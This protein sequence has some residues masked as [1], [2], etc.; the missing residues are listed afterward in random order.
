MTKMKH[1]FISFRFF[2]FGLFWNVII[3]TCVCV[4]MLVRLTATRWTSQNIAILDQNVKVW[5]SFERNVNCGRKRN[6]IGNIKIHSCAPNKSTT[7][8]GYEAGDRTISWTSQLNRLI[9]NRISFHWANRQCV[10]FG[11]GYQRNSRHSIHSVPWY[12]QNH[13]SAER[14]RPKWMRKKNR[15]KQIM[16]RSHSGV[17]YLEKRNQDFHHQFE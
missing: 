13:N 7:R 16:N 12:A 6:R 9:V 4:G 15:R 2:W 10:L 3:V 1:H 8:N 5:I 11:G 14:I 17:S